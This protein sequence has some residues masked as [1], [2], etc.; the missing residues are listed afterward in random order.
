MLFLWAGVACTIFGA[1]TEV[2]F[3]FRT[4][5]QRRTQVIWVFSL[6]IIAKIL[7]I[8][9]IVLRVYDTPNSLF[10]LLGCIVLSFIWFFLSQVVKPSKEGHQDFLDVE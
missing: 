3:F 4:S 9:A 2:Y 1:G 7:L 6:G 10:I 8:A 5:P